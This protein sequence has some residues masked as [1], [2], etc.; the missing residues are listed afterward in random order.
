MTTP[1]RTASGATKRFCPSVSPPGQEKPSMDQVLKQI[2][3]SVSV[4]DC[5]KIAIN[6]LVEELS[7]VKL[8]RD[9]LYEE[10]L[11]LRRQL[12]L[13]SDDGNVAMVASTNRDSSDPVSVSSGTRNSFPD[14]S[15][16]CQEIER[17]RSVIICGI[18]E[19][20][21]SSIQARVRYDYLMLESFFSTLMSIVF[22]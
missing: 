4:P 9:K 21:S 16:C 3:D 17:R 15:T 7:L 5:L 18:P 13:R 6:I 12:G 19:L 10:N 14:G 11:T 2:N 8:E 22:P 20:D 1:V